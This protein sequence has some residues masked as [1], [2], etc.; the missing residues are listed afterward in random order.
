MILP[1]GTVHEYST[2][3]HIPQQTYKDSHYVSM[4]EALLQSGHVRNGE[5]YNLPGEGHTLQQEGGVRGESRKPVN[6]EGG[7]YEQVRHESNGQS[8]TETETESE[9]SSGT[10]HHEPHR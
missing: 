7:E 8:E 2:V 6:L 1:D 9:S 10:V 3:Q 4:K 5:Y